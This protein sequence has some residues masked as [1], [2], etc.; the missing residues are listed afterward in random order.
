[1]ID[2]APR[3]PLN[4][5]ATEQSGLLGA[6][7]ITRSLSDDCAVIDGDRSLSWRA[8][9]DTVVRTAD[10]LRA[11]GVS[12]GDA[13]C[14][15]LPNRLEA[16]VV[17]LAALRIGAVSTPIVPIYRHHEVGFILRQSKAPVIIVPDQFRG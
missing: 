12:A 11:L 2:A 3:S 8:L 16:V 5:A 17:H 1:M 9:A 4:D 14:W 6:P 7:F 10:G 13:V 15:Q